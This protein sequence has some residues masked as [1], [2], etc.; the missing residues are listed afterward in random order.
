MVIVATPRI[1]LFLSALLNQIQFDKIRGCIEAGEALP[2]ILLT[3]SFYSSLKYLIITGKGEANKEY[4][5][6]RA[7]KDKRRQ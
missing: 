2:K 7:S 3:A 1:L 6:R 5:E 4:H